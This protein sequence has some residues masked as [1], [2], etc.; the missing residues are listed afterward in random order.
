MKKSLANLILKLVEFLGLKKDILA[1]DMA[2]AELHDAALAGLLS[3]AESLE[4]VKAALT[5]AGAASD[6]KKFDLAVSELVVERPSSLYGAV[7]DPRA[8]EI[9][10][11]SPVVFETIVESEALARRLKNDDSLV[12]ELVNSREGWERVARVASISRGCA[13]VSP[14][15]VVR[16]GDDQGLIPS[17]A[18]W[19]VGA[20]LVENLIRNPALSDFIFCRTALQERLEK[21]ESL[22]ED[23]VASDAIWNRISGRATASRDC[24]IL[25][26]S[27]VLHSPNDE[28]LV[29]V[30]FEWIIGARLLP[31]LVEIPE[32]ASSLFSNTAVLE[33]IAADESLV[34]SLVASDL[35]WDRLSRWASTSRSC[36]IIYPDSVTSSPSDNALVNRLSDWICGAGLMDFL[37]GE[38]EFLLEVAKA[39]SFSKL[40]E[41]RLSVEGKLDDAN[42]AFN[43]ATRRSLV[44]CV[45]L[46]D[47]NL[48]EEALV[49]KWVSEE[50]LSS[51]LKDLISNNAK[52]T[53]DVDFVDS[54]IAFNTKQFDRS[55]ESRLLSGKSS[56]VLFAGLRW[57]AETIN[58]GQPPKCSVLAEML[59][60]AGLFVRS[61]PSNE[62]SELGLDPILCGNSAK[63]FDV[64]YTL[65]TSRKEHVITA[66]DRILENKLACN[67]IARYFT[68]EILLLQDKQK[69]RLLRNS[70]I[71]VLE[72][73]GYVVWIGSVGSSSLSKDK[74]F[75]RSELD[76]DMLLLFDLLFEYRKWRERVLEKGL[77]SCTPSEFIELLSRNKKLSESLLSTDEIFE[78]FLSKNLRKISHDNRIRRYKLVD[79][80]KSG[81]VVG[82]EEATL[83]SFRS[84][85][86][87]AIG[88]LSM[89]ERTK[90]R[91]MLAEEG[92]MQRNL[93]F[94]EAV[95][96][97]IWCDDYVELSNG[98]LYFPDGEAVLTLIEEILINE[99][100][101]FE[102]TNPESVII[103]CGTH[104]GVSLY[105][106]RKQFP[107]KKIICFEPSKRAYSVLK[108]NIKENGWV[109][110]DSH[111]SALSNKRVTLNFYDQTYQ[112]M[113]GSL[114]R[115]KGDKNS[116][117]HKIKVELLS[118][119]LDQSVDFL[120]LDLEGEEMK[121]LQEIES[122]LENVNAIFCEYHEATCPTPL[123][124]V[125]GLLRKNGYQVKVSLSDY[126]LRVTKRR[127]LKHTANAC[128]YVL[129]AKRV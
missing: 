96:K 16:S 91:I 119:Y 66:I 82:P 72:K 28:A 120:K 32:F 10:K 50:S 77:G 90:K 18:N 59:N 79:S 97:A 107:K 58:S 46:S 12:E 113:A 37:L 88:H 15:D 24:A 85:I 39:A 95:K 42:S 61:Q 106:Y 43:K 2:K 25:S 114:K 36:A 70:F 11:R 89:D 109:S 73:T 74:R 76:E 51:K 7:Q 63:D 67:N 41:V 123:E 125:V 49:S 23:L 124:D 99:C 31:S 118:P 98:K 86:S 38:P 4:L 45:L 80:L 71:K 44:D 64:L 121:V 52:V 8:K 65:L 103:D 29:P 19:I 87:D 57:V 33:R 13:I 115:R 62:L 111:N 127:P 47:G 129:Y 78:L 14:E 26:A 110:I 126:Y 83:S 35:V 34:E 27:G 117:A 1:S 22:V 94:D 9:L 93:K 30:L 17:L 128:S 5:G 69:F 101:Y 108:R 116:K 6:S 55:Y 48:V 21:D 60:N 75:L 84:F 112:S 100:Y 92:I 104:Y 3:P 53:L 68:D 102:E 54:L 122:K 81:E 40:V 56:E 105:Y 20:G